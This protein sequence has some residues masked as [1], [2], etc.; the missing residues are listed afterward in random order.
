MLLPRNFV[1]VKSRPLVHHELIRRGNYK[2]LW[3]ELHLIEVVN[4]VYQLRG[5]QKLRRIQFLC[6]VVIYEI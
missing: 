5:L 3:D 4:W 2:I 1:H 6:D